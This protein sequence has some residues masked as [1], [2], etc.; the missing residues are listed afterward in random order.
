MAGL[1]L[2]D[3]ATRNLMLPFTYT[4]P[5]CDCLIGM[6]N[7]REKWEQRFN[8]ISSTWT[9]DYLSRK[10]PLQTDEDTLWINGSILPDTTLVGAISTLQHGERLQAGATWLAARSGYL[11]SMHE[12]QRLRAVSYPESFDHIQYPWDLFQKNRK[13]FE[14]DLAYRSPMPVGALVPEHCTLIHP[15]RIFIEPGAEVLCSILNASEGPIYLSKGSRVME[16]CLIRGPFF[17]GQGSVLKMGTRIYGATSIGSGCVVGGEIKNSIFFGNSN[18]GHDGYVGDAV[19]GE[20]CNLG[21]NTN[22]SNLKNNI[23]PVRIWSEHEQSFSVAGTK[24]GML[25]GDFS[26]TGINTMINTGSLIGVSCNIFGAD[27]PPSYLP[28]FSWGSR[29]HLEAYRLSHALRDAAAWK[30]LKHQTLSP[31]EEHLLSDVY[32]LTSPYRKYLAQS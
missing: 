7:I 4:R 16:G 22:C 10:F 12:L 31:E 14:Q 9:V 8:Q 25:M 23:S 20:W 15:E 29:Q 5:V 19:I 6:S 1:V 24:C 32:V 11:A 17:L 30:H 28:S 13:T 26:R 2:C 18:K 27:F 21:A 3:T